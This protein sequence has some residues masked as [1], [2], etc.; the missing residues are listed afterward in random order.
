MKNRI[1]VIDDDE[2]VRETICDTLISAE[3]SITAA[4]DGEQGVKE[5]RRSQFDLVITD[6]LMPKQEGIETILHLRRDHPDS[7][8]VAISGSGAFD[9]SSYLQMAKKL[10]AAAT[11]QKPFSAEEL[12]NMVSSVLDEPNPTRVDA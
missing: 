1:L 9:N 11:L 12:I 10:G 8:V 5:C 4:A 3:F 7:K 2:T 6:I